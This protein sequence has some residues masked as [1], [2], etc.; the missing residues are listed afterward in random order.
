MNPLNATTR[1][2]QTRLQQY[3]TTTLVTASLS[4]H[5]TRMRFL[6]DV[7]TAGLF[8]ALC[9]GLRTISTK[10]GLYS[11]DCYSHQIP[12]GVMSSRAPMS[13]PTRIYDWQR[14]PPGQPLVTSDAKAMHTSSHTPIK[15]PIACRSCIRGTQWRGDSCSIA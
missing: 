8:R 2:E 15:V 6:A 3:P 4:G 5:L 14:R 1:A 12:R 13:P 10:F 7:F 11:F 9:D